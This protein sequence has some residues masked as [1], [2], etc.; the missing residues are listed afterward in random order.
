MRQLITPKL[1]TIFVGLL[2]VT[3]AYSFMSDEYITWKASLA[4]DAKCQ[5]LGCKSGNL[6]NNMDDLTKV[7]RCEG[8]QDYLII[9]N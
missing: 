9:V 8:D 2:T 3:S 6:F 4:C 1:V 7:C 5:L